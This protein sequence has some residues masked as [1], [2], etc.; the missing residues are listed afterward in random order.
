MQLTNY[1][2][3]FKKG[4]SII[5]PSWDRLDYL[6]AAIYSI[7]AWS[8]FDHEIIVHVN[9]STDGTQDFLARNEIK[10]TESADNLGVAEAVNC[11]AKEASKDV[12]FFTDNDILLLPGW[13][14]ELAAF[15]LDNNA[16]SNWWINSLMIEPNGSNPCCIA[17]YNYG[18]HPALFEEK[19][20]LNDLP[21]FRNKDSLVS[22]YMPVALSKK[23]WEELDGA[24]T[25]LKAMGC[26][27]DDEL[28]FSYWHTLGSRNFPTAPKS[29]CYHFQAGMSGARPNPMGNEAGKTRD[30]FFKDTHGI[31]LN[32]FLNDTIK[33]GSTWTPR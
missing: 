3:L 11:A 17:P 27:W 4:F 7:Q 5:I 15:A 9:G 23:A 25:E 1:P 21:K 16:K 10:F 20:L 32:L 30:K 18:R 6:K 14:S 24:D 22:T 26:G 8:S 13:D 19:R 2:D 12:L 28:A 29:L 33:R 31:D